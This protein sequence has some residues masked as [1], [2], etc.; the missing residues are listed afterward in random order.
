[1]KPV[2]VV[3]LGG[4]IGV[5]AFLRAAH[6]GL[7]WRTAV[8]SKVVTTFMRYSTLSEWIHE[9]N[10][11]DPVALR[12]RLNG[13]A[14]DN[15][16]H[17]LVLFTN[18]DWTVRAIIQQREHLDPRWHVPLCS[19]EAFDKVS[20]KTGFQTLCDDLGI[21]T[22][23][24]L[25]VGFT[26]SAVAAGALTPD[27]AVEQI[28]ARGLEFPL[29]GKPSASADWFEVDFP[30]KLK[31]HHFHS[32][33]ELREVLEHL[34]ERNYPSEFLVQE[35]V[36]GD[37]THMRSLTAYRD[38]SG[39]TSLLAG[40]QVLLEEHTPGTLGIPAAI[41]TGVDQPAFDDA[42]RL[43]DAAGYT[44]FANFDYKVSSRTGENVFFEVNPRI[45][46]NNH[47]V[48][49]AGVNVAEVLARDLLPQYAT[50]D[51][52]ALT[53]TKEVLYSVVPWRLL[54]RYLLDDAL[55][56]KVD[57]ARK[58]HGIAHPL[59]YGADASL[60]RRIYVRLLDMRLAR[61]YKEFY[62]EPTADGL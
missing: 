60:K 8:V 19:L 28:E 37:E 38:S 50:G 58:R 29:I 44:G 35:F 14:A 62:P 7:G 17:E 34:A 5:Y 27:S 1:M 4:D 42:R 39:E 54:K 6:E 9:P 25:D 22:P 32:T 52:P 55:R 57:D 47:Y 40:G 59:R 33:A 12:D 2:L 31:I 53:P 3:G 21:R 30:G 18:L 56:A 26:A 15:P 46:R 16:D 48:T 36:P 20:S 23:V 61:K 11:A 13:I 10:M 43:L 49:A 51:A 41:L 24:T 45:G